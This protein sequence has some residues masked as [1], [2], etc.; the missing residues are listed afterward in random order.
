MT[1]PAPPAVAD[2]Q[3]VSVP[4]VPNS[5][6]CVVI[7]ALVVPGKHVGPPRPYP[8]NLADRKASGM[9]EFHELLSK[10]W[11]SKEDIQKL[12]A[13]GQLSQ[14]TASRLDSLIDLY[15]KG[16]FHRFGWYLIQHVGAK[17]MVLAYRDPAVFYLQEYAAHLKPEDK[18]VDTSAL[19]TKEGEVKFAEK[20]AAPKAA[21]APRAKKADVPASTAKAS[22]APAGGYVARLR[23]LGIG[24][25]YD[26]LVCDQDQGGFVVAAAKDK[27]EAIIN[28]NGVGGPQAVTPLSAM[29]KNGFL[30]AGFFKKFRDLEDAYKAAEEKSNTAQPVAQ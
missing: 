3:V 28:E 29:Q 4:G 7:K 8:W 15:S 21:R 24:P 22:S 14:L 27:V 16:T 18:V 11:Q 26:A 17:K 13:D 25:L 30:H 20:V 23:E 2:A 12:I 9:Y 10:N 19:D 5:E 6:G 1:S